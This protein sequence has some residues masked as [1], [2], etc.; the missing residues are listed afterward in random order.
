MR[1][2][3]SDQVAAA[4]WNDAE[5]VFRILLEHRPLERIEL[6]TDENGDGHAVLRCL[7]S[8][9]PATNA[10]RLRKGAKRRSN[11][12]LRVWRDG[13]LRFARNDGGC[14]SDPDNTRLN[15]G[16]ASANIEL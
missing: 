3:V 9:L 16:D 2:P 8:S 12:F 4:P 13:L 1:H 5:P 10:K 6:V 7:L 14:F 11:P 15:V